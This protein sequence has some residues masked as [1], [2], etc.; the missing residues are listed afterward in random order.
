[1]I[2]AAKRR[3]EIIQLKNSPKG[4]VLAP[5]PH[6]PSRLPL[7]LRRPHFPPSVNPY[8]VQGS[9]GGQSLSSRQDGQASEPRQKCP[10][11]VSPADWIYALRDF[12]LL[13]KSASSMTEMS[14]PSLVATR[15]FWMLL[16]NRPASKKQRKERILLSAVPA[17]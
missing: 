3:K 13:M 7:H 15:T 11:E 1:M 17:D 12:Q 2:G 16:Q 4:K 9:G 5:F 10:V 14:S 8:S 6:F